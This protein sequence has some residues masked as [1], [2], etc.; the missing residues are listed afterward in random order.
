MNYIWP[1]AKIKVLGSTYILKAL[2]CIE[3]SHYVAYAR[4]GRGSPWY[5]FDSMSDRKNNQN[6]PL[7]REVDLSALEASTWSQS[8]L[9]SKDISRIATDVA[10]CFYSF[11]EDST[12]ES[13]QKEEIRVE[14]EQEKLPEKPKEDHSV[15]LQDKPIEK[16]NEDL[17]KP[18]QMDIIS[19]TSGSTSDQK[20]VEMDVTPQPSGSTSEPTGQQQ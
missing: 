17:Q 3:T 20:P 15:P 16:L 4:A 6:I 14:K 2:C 1:S 13:N 9:D 11:A 18:V 7:I 8:M 19:P 12:P 5:F 10:V